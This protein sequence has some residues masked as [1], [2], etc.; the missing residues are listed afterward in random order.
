MTG[1]SP[2]AETIPVPSSCP[3]APLVGAIAEVSSF[4]CKQFSMIFAE[5]FNV[6]RAENLPRECRFGPGQ[7][8]PLLLLY[9]RE[10]C[11]RFS[12]I[13]FGASHDRQA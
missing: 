2:L 6:S 9:A 3:L 7:G 13:F 11:Y 12:M 1:R 4:R 8:R 10:S 5:I